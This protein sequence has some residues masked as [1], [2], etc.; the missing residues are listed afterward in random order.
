MADRVSAIECGG[1]GAFHVSA[2][3]SGL[4]D[5]INEKVDLLKRHLPYRE[6][7]HVLN[8][9]QPLMHILLREGHRGEGKFASGEFIKCVFV[10]WFCYGGFRVI[11]GKFS[12][13]RRL[14][15]FPV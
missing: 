11:N 7:D 8:I 12:G 1:I 13:Q 2:C 3:N 15:S 9:G 10:G 5:N 6:S 4:V 14:V